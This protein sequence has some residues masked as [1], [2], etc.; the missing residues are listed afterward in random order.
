MLIATNIMKSKK[1]YNRVN[2]KT[3]H[4]SD[5]YLVRPSTRKETEDEHVKHIKT[6]INRGFTPRWYI[7]FHLV[8]IDYPPDDP[9]WDKYL[10][11]LRNSLWTAIY[12]SN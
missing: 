9:I 1:R 10:G 6:Q 12:K 5:L 7:V 2:P 8:D 3:I 4:K 11:R